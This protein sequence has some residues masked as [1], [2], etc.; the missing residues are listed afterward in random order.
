MTLTAE[1]SRRRH[2]VDD[3]ATAAGSAL[4]HD[5]RLL[6]AA[7]RHRRAVPLGPRLVGLGQHYYAAAAQA[8]TQD[9]KAWLF[10]SLDAGNAITVDKPPAAMWV[11]GVV[12][13]ALRLQRVHHAAAAGA[14]GRRRGR[15]AVPTVRRTSGP[16][17]R[18]DRRAGAGADAGRDADVP[19]QQ[20]RRAAG[21][22]A[23][24]RGVLHGAR[25]RRRPAAERRGW[26]WPAASSASRS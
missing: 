15:A 1:T 22:A 7:G 5:P 6:G 19:L 23:G 14:D 13:Q 25:D 4:G 26:R 12:R 8:G 11:M 9:W 16:G 18:P 24:R 10:G 21:A 3:R 17:R 2:A 20:P